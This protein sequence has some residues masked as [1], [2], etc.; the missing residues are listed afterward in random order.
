MS[1]KVARCVGTNPVTTSSETTFSRDSPMCTVFGAACLSRNELLAATMR[2][3]RS[4]LFHPMAMK[5]TAR[6]EWF[7]F[8]DKHLSFP[9]LKHL[10]AFMP[11]IRGDIAEL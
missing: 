5:N 9:T 11:C 6:V 3:G 4:V 2:S 10:Y 7:T 1:L 8:F